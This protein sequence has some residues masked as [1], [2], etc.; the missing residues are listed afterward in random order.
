MSF[1]EWTSLVLAVISTGITAFIA[2]ITWK[3]YQGSMAPPAP[4]ETNPVTA[5]NDKTGED[6]TYINMAIGIIKDE[7]RLHLGFQRIVFLAP[8][9]LGLFISF[10]ILIFLPQLSYISIYVTI[11][12]TIISFII[13]F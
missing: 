4:G 1:F 6:Y 3:Q 11:I 2:S 13:S 8:M 5:P 9:F 10:I 12:C 7:F